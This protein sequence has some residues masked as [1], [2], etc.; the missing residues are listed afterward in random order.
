MH[1]LVFCSCAGCTILGCGLGGFGC[2]D[3]VL[4]RLIV[5]SCSIGCGVESLLVSVHLRLLLAP[6]PLSRLSS[7]SSPPG[8]WKD[9]VTIGQT[10]YIMAAL[11][12]APQSLH[13]ARLSCCL[14][15]PDYP[16][17]IFIFRG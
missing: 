4:A 6:P 12:V 16:E 3:I 15:T 9:Y 13:D 11:Q 14:L 7:L 5:D 8:V 10:R 17:V 2:H 1:L